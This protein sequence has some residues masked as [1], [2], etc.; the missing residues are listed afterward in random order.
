MISIVIVRSKQLRKGGID[1][2]YSTSQNEAFHG[3]VRKLLS[4]KGGLRRRIAIV[5]GSV[6]SKINGRRNGEERRKGEEI[7][8]S[9]EPK[10]IKP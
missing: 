7:T 10:A 3:F 5:G 4:A 1:V 2:V 8:R 6:H 9:C